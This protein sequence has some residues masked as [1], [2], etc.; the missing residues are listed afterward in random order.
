MEDKIKLVLHN[1]QQTVSC[2]QKYLKVLENYYHKVIFHIGIDTKKPRTLDFLAQFVCALVKA[3]ENEPQQFL[4]DDLPSHPFL[5]EV[6]NETLKYHDLA[7]VQARY[8]S[9]RFLTLILKHIGHD[10][11][12]D[13]DICDS[14]QDALLERIL[15]PKASIRLQAVIAMVRLQEPINLDCPVINAYQSLLLDANPLIRKEVVKLIAPNAVTISK[16]SER[17]S[18]VDS[19]VR[20]AAYKRCSDI[21][22]MLFKIIARQQILKCGFNETNKS[23][24]NVFMENLL[25]KWLTAYNGNFLSLLAGIKLDADEN[26]ILNTEEISKQVMEAFFETTPI[27]EII[28]YLPVDE[29]RLVPMNKL[30]SEVITYWSI[31]TNFLRNSEDADEY[32]DNILPELTPFCN[33]IQ[34]IIESKNLQNMKEW[35]YLDHQYVL[36]NLFDMAEQYDLSDEVGRRTF[37]KLVRSVLQHQHLQFKLAKKV[38]GIADK[39]ISNV[40]IFTNEICQIISDIREPLVDRPSEQEESSEKVFQ[41]AELK[42]LGLG[43]QSDDPETICQCLDLL[44]ALLQLPSVNVVSPSLATCKNEF[45]LPLLTSSVVEINWR[46]LRCLAL[47]SLLDKSIA[48]EHIKVLCI[49]IATYRAI[50]NYNKFA[51]ITSVAAVCDLIQL[52]G[53]EIFGTDEDTTNTTTN[54]NNT[55][56]RRLYRNEGADDVTVIDNNNRMNVEFIIEIVLDML[57]DENDEIREIVITAITKLILSEFPVNPLLISRIILK[58]FNPLT[59]KSSDKIQQKLGTLIV[60]YTK[61][62]KGAREVIETAVIPTLTTI[63]H[64]PRAS[65]LAD[66]DID[67]VL[68]FLAAITNSSDT[69]DIVHVHTHL[70]QSLCFKIANKPSDPVVPYLSKMLLHLEI[71]EN[72]SSIKELITQAELLLLEEEDILMKGPRR[73]I[74]KFVEKLKTVQIEDNTEGTINI[75]DNTKEMEKSSNVDCSAINNENSDNQEVP[76]EEQ[77]TVNESEYNNGTVAIKEYMK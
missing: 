21:G 43:C 63:A 35:E 47:Y 17:I 11:N 66:I 51:V 27:R 58:W 40:D 61:L 73:N 44:S 39:L 37:Q 49:P 6:I 67:N 13:S 32:L 20:I 23:A 75:D 62:V 38:I 33:Y 16:I 74:R 68:R 31:I 65:P 36:Y 26:D 34:R 42:L 57:D 53:S 48:E 60:N 46:V 19:H 3:N 72:S 2:H 52:Y 30:S 9:C 28:E 14:I 41:V 8:H 7:Y 54:T 25:P 59:E 45:L 5:T 24:K 71:P 76:N 69:M 1:V 55:T 22:P 29:N 56:R 70:A 4:E 64:A 18:D 77:N 50:P 12:L 10:T 15:D